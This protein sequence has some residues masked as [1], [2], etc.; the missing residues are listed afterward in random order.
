MQIPAVQHEAGELSLFVVEL[1]HGSVT[2]VESKLP[3]DQRQ[4]SG[5]NRPCLGDQI[6]TGIIR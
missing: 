2:R 4:S 6:S 5:D 1:G 3:E